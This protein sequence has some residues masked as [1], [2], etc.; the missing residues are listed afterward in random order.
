MSLKL[1]VLLCGVIPFGGLSKNRSK[2]TLDSESF[3]FLQSIGSPSALHNA[4]RHLNKTNASSYGLSGES[5]ETFQHNIDSKITSISEDVLA[6]KY[7][8]SKNRAALI[9]KDNGSLR[10]LQIPE[11]RDR[12]VLKSLAIV[13][14]KSFKH[15]LER[16]KGVSFAYQEKTGIE[17]VTKKIK[18]YHD[19]GYK[20]VL[21]AD[22]VKFFDKLEKTRLLT[23]YVYPNIPNASKIQD[24]I[25]NGLSQ[26]LD[27]SKINAENLKYFEGL[28][29]GIPQG[30]PLSPL[31]SNIY[32]A[33]FDSYMVEKSYKLIRYA[34]DFIVMLKSEEE[35][36]ACFTKAGIFLKESLNLD[37]HPLGEKSKII[38]LDKEPFTFLS[39]TYDGTNFYPGSKSIELLKRK[40]DKICFGPTS[41]ETVLKILT[42]LKN[43]LEGWLSSYSFTDVDRYND[44]IDSFIN[45][46]TLRALEGK[47]WRFTTA[48]KGKLKSKY[49]VHGEDPYCLSDIQRAASGIPF[50]SQILKERRA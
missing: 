9:P 24:L 13:I 50:C 49:R 41:E 43:T 45:K 32:L 26:Q 17:D 39:I 27:I 2:M 11:I 6:G 34:D 47:K 44:E 25:E 48:S 42:K 38:N 15:I 18:E 31:L 8:F 33:P 21:E 5:I 19:Q 40:I 22:I 20:W 30:N 14:E 36:K 3:E 46:Q 7:R 4:W 10:P 16:S 23:Q 28:G 1:R 12:L 35:A 29:S 37:L